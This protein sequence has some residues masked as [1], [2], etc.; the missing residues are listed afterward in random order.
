LPWFLSKVKGEETGRVK[1]RQRVRSYLQVIGRLF[2]LGWGWLVAALTESEAL[3]INNPEKR[4]K[5]GFNKMSIGCTLIKSTNPSP[6][7]QQ[8]VSSS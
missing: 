7:Y 6:T 8:P 2:W 1:K 4:K 3:L 5:R